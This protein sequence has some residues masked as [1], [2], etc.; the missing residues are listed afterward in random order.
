MTLRQIVI[1]CILIALLSVAMLAALVI[2]T[3]PSTPTMTLAMILT[4]LAITAA[5][6]PILGRIQQKIA[7]PTRPT[8]LP[9]LAIRQGF[10]MGLYL[11]A[12]LVLYLRNLLDPIFALVLFTLFILIEN[13]LQTRANWRQP[14]P[15][16]KTSSTKPGAKASSRRP[17]AKFR[18]TGTQPRK[19]SKSKAKTTKIHPKSSKKTPPKN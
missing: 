14:R 17:A 16:Q 15:K 10:W 12:L 18:R 3:P 2:Y 13:F 1:P 6:A 8:D 4:I 19:Q 7:P 11:V 5:A 9:Y